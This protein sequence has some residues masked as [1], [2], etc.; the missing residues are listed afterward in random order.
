MINRHWLERFPLSDKVYLTIIVKVSLNIAM[1]RL[2]I[3]VP[4]LKQTRLL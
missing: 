1:L 3:L 2:M 4:E